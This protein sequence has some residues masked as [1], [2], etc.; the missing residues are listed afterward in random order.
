[1]ADPVSSEEVTVNLS[2]LNQFSLFS[3]LLSQ[4]NKAIV[5]TG[6]VRIVWL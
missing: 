5:L 1:M 4:M 6:I 2:F 3:L